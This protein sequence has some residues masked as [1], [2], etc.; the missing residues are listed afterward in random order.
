[1]ARRKSGA[2]R[3]RSPRR[4]AAQT[5][6]PAER[7]YHAGPGAPFGDDEA[8]AIGHELDRIREEDALTAEAIIEAARIEASPLH[9]HFDWDDETAAHKHRVNR[10]KKILGWVRIE[11]VINDRTQRVRANARIYR[12]HEGRIKQYAPIEQVLGHEESRKRLLLQAWTN[13]KTW[14]RQY[15]M[16]SE[17]GTIFT[18]VDEMED[19]SSG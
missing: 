2:A 6:E 18:V 8:D 17:L 10:A 4:S 7:K 11:Y 15:A 19:Q 13:L 14:R 16:L 5:R 3:K 12:S 1:M 9:R